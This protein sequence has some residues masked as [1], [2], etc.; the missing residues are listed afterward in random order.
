M[1]VES[2]QWR[3]CLFTRQSELSS[4]QMYLI[5]KEIMLVESYES[6]RQRKLS[7][8]QIAKNSSRR[9]DIESLILVM[10]E[11]DSNVMVV[12]SYEWR[13]CLPNRQSKLTSGQMHLIKADLEILL[14]VM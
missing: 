11:R 6:T 12:E 8:G 2:Y 14:L 4:G 10:L 1:V 3:K 13:K 7:S 5:L 9:G